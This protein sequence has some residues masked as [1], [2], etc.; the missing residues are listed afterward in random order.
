MMKPGS[1]AAAPS[2]EATLGLSELIVDLVHTEKIMHAQLLVITSAVYVYHE[3]LI[4]LD[5]L[6]EIWLDNNK[7][8]LPIT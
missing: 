4:Q 8:E 5:K 7:K 1:S 2:I 3:K 6:M